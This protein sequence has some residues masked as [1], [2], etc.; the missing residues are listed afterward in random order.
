MIL[1]DQL[2]LVVVKTYPFKERVQREN[3]ALQPPSSTQSRSRSGSSTGYIS[4]L[5]GRI[6][7][8]I[9]LAFIDASLF[10]KQL[11]RVQRRLSY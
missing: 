5:I 1:H 10:R 4:P 11:L 2:G 9:F 3:K 7:L 6:N 8:P